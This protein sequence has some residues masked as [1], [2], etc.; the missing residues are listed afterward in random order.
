RFSDLFKLH[1]RQSELDFVDIP[2]N[3]DIALFVDPYALT[4]AGDDS[5]RSCSDDVVEYFDLILKA[6]IS[7]DRT[8]VLE[9]LSNFHEPND[10]HLGLSKGEP[11][12][13]GWGQKQTAQLYE[14]LSKSRA[15]KSGSIKDIT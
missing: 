13:R 15:V 10:T 3:T 6:I 12:G 14:R 5:L 1:K 7:K 4:V 11:S 9:L 8:R 2:L